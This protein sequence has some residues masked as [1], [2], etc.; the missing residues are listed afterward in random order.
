MTNYAFFDVDQTI[1]PGYS[2][3]DFY[4]SSVVADR[5]GAD[6]HRQDLE[7]GALYQ[8]GQISYGEAGARAAKL[9]ASTMKGES[10]GT[11][12]SL[13]LSFIAEHGLKSFVDPLFTLLHKHS[14]S[15][16]LVSGSVEFIVHAIA[17][18]SHADHYLS[19]TIKKNEDD[20]Y[21]GQ[22]LH[23]LDNEEKNI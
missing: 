20:T 15:I 1:Y 2:M 9:C 18:H 5:G 19:T 10:V 16:V 6:I 11:A 12:K 21:T 4:L 13:A 17:K 8:S 3:A 7:I 14:Y 22:V 23:Q